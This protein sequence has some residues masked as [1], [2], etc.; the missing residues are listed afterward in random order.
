VDRA[1][2]FHAQLSGLG[3][4]FEVHA[5]Q[6]RCPAERLGKGEHTEDAYDGGG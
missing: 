1:G 4:P 3:D 2:D 6:Q 5:G